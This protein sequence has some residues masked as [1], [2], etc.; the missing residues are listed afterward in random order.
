MNGVEAA[1][2][3]RRTMP[4]VPIVLLTMYENFLGSSLTLAGVTAV[5]SKTDGM[6]KL[7]ACVHSLLNPAQILE[8]G[9][10]HVTA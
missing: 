7:V 5:V 9:D 2:I 10:A 6:D 1:A 4:G 8:G 3:L